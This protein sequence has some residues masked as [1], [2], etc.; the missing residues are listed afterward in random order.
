MRLLGPPC[1]VYEDSAHFSPEQMLLLG[2]VER[3]I[4]DLS[5][6]VPPIIRRDAVSWFENPQVEATHYGYSYRYCIEHI[7]LAP[8]YQ[9]M[10]HRLVVAAKAYDTIRVREG[11]CA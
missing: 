7:D 4:R 8:E 2:I 11:L 9:Q 3:A 5:S 10:I 1:F 6:I